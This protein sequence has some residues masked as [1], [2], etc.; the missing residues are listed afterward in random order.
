MLQL[1]PYQKEIIMIDDVDRLTG[2]EVMEVLRI[3]RNTANFS[4][5]FF[6]VGVDQKYIVNVL[7]NTNDFANEEEY[8]KKVFQLTITLPAFKK[9]VVINV[10]SLFLITDDLSED[11]KN[12]LSEALS[13]LAHDPDGLA[14]AA[15]PAL[16][17]E[18]I[19]EKFID[20][21]RDLKRFC[22]SFKIAYNIL[23]GEIDIHD[24]MVLEL[25]RNRNIEFYNLIRN[26]TLLN[27]D[28]D[29]TNEFI[30]NEESWKIYENEIKDTISKNDLRNFKEALTYLVTDQE[31]KNSRKFKIVYNFYLYFSYQLFN[32][33]SFNEYNELI[34][35]DA[36]EIITKFDQWSAEGKQPELL[37]IAAQVT[38]FPDSDFLLKM[39]VVYSNIQMNHDAW[40]PYEYKLVFHFR[41]Y[42]HERY[43]GKDM[44][45]HKDFLIKLMKTNSIP[46]YDRAALANNFLLGH[47]N[48]QPN[49]QS[50]ILSK[51]EWQKWRF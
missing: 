26:R 3:I 1:K 50:F 20:N 24:L 47:I 4:N 46:L 49:E 39:I 34:L 11:E 6:V 33:V 48:K 25:I 31:Y 35:K 5:T 12:I 27:F 45:K 37:R 10:A 41:A 42:N 14:A 2:K 32:L 44:Q 23:K 21:V 38:D 7:K 22:N 9:D 30:M 8:L 51:N 43:F 28:I 29:R 13:K 40:F 16:D 18:H 19:F 15:Y 17:N 36:K